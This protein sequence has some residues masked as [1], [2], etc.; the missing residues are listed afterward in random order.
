MLFLCH[1]AKSAS[2]IRIGHASW[3]VFD[4][5]CPGDRLALILNV[6]P[7][8]KSQQTRQQLLEKLSSLPVTGISAGFTSDAATDPELAKALLDAC[9]SEALREPPE[10][11]LLILPERSHRPDFALRVLLSN[12]LEWA[13]FNFFLAEA[14]NKASL[15]LHEVV[16]LLDQCVCR[17]RT[18][19]IPNL[20]QMAAAGVSDSEVSTVLELAKAK[21]VSLM[22]LSSVAP[23]ERRSLLMEEFLRSVPQEQ[24]LVSLDKDERDLASLLAV[25]QHSGD[26]AILKSAGLGKALDF[27]LEDRCEAGRWP[28]VG[29]LLLRTLKEALPGRVAARV[30]L[31]WFQDEASRAGLGPVVAEAV[32]VQLQ[33][34]A[35]EDF[36]SRW[37]VFQT[38]S[39]AWEACDESL[40]RQALEL[41]ARF[42]R[43]GGQQTGAVNMLRCLPLSR[44]SDSS[45]L[46]A[47]G[48]PPA[49][50]GIYAERRARF[51]HEQLLQQL[52]QVE[53][54]ARSAQTCAEQ[55]LA[56][57][58][59]ADEK[60]THADNTATHADNKAA[61]AAELADHAENIASEALRVASAARRDSDS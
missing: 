27:L 8:L 22:F 3:K 14:L 58:Q 52:Q 18:D 20:I 61:R 9:P 54:L 34:C 24:L 13:V 12:E 35:D 17:G 15:Q 45:A 56:L 11:S 44:L 37:P 16:P 57:A 26:P 32:V 59:E 36:A 21:Q 46:F 4:K 19:C 31:A 51:E 41:L 28:R 2:D 60:A 48:M 23:L 42:C 6:V 55:A 5:A 7:K 1:T 43:L 53:R 33:Q 50:H 10:T 49:A 47:D 25:A 38:W 30:P 29:P 40:C 39:D